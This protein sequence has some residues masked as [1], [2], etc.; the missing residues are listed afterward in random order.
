VRGCRHQS[1]RAR[2]ARIFRPITSKGLY[3]ALAAI[4]V[5]G[6]I[7]GSSQACS[8]SAPAS[9]V[10]VQFA[11][12]SSSPPEDI[13]VQISDS[14]ITTLHRERAMSGEADLYKG[15]VA[16]K[17]LAAVIHALNQRADVRYAEA[18]RKLGY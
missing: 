18:D 1:D 3:L 8:L 2:V 13:K 4:L 10:I 15:C 7:Y 16:K 12:T 17:R 14:A 11:D 9:R 5:M 6:C